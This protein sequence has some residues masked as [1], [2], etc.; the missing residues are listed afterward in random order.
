MATPPKKLKFVEAFNDAT[1]GRNAQEQTGYEKVD[2]YR[3]AERFFHPILWQRF[4]PQ[5]TIQ[6]VTVTLYDFKSFTAT[7]STMAVDKNLSL[8]GDVK[9]TV[10]PFSAFDNKAALRD[11]HR[12]L[13]ELGGNPP[14]LEDLASV[15]LMPGKNLEAPSRAQFKP[16]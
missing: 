16:K 4:E 5:V 2:D 12:A 9:H 8:Q 15:L 14:E 13:K 3:V 6:Q 11:A 1:D 7:I 10:I